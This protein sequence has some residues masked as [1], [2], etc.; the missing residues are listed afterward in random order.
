MWGFRPNR[1]FT[2][3]R[4]GFFAKGRIERLI[5]ELGFGV[6]RHAC[7]EPERLLHMRALGVGVALPALKQT[8]LPR[9]EIGRQHHR[10]FSRD[11]IQDIL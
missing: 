11:V 5:E 2:R 6:R 8:L 7:V 4:R 3:W 1:E 10:T 9:V